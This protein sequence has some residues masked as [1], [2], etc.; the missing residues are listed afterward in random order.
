MYKVGLLVH[1]MLCW[2]FVGFVQLAFGAGSF[3]F[4]LLYNFSSF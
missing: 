1:F 2:V 4:P 3:G